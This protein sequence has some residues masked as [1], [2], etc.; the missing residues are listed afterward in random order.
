MRRRGADRRAVAKGERIDGVIGFGG[1]SSMD[2]AKLVA[3]L[4]EPTQKQ[5]MGEMYGIGNVK[6][7]R[8]PLV[9][10]PTTAGTGSEVTHLSIVTIS[11]TAKAAVG[12]TLLLPDVAVL[13]ADL[14]AALPSHVAAATGIDAMVHAIEAYTC[15]GANGKNPLSD[16]LAREA[17]Q[18]LGANIHEACAPD[19]SSES[20]G[21][22]LLG[23][24]YAGMA[25]ANS[26]VAAV[27]ALAYPLGAR[28][29]VPHGLSNS[30]VLPHVLAF[31][32]AEP[33]AARQ[34]GELAPHAFPGLGADAGVARFIE[35]FA[36]LPVQLGLPTRLSEVGVAEADVEMLAA[37]AMEQTRL[38]G[39]NPRAVRQ[40][41]A[42]RVYRQAL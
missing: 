13:D 29:G 17:L 39:N 36:E 27:H 24:C 40:E 35:K 25:F 7:P 8:L 12:D 14:T 19:A 41:D 18:L 5:P 34:Y 15:V 31:N 33:I 9:Q 4:A 37:A 38:L 16:V 32:A 21:A 11:D 28:F 10:V 22:M 3:L 2:I 26:P 42:A 6:G 20:R 23:S 1:G 30:L